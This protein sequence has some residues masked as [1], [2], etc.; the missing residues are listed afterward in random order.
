MP[1][2]WCSVNFIAG[3][4]SLLFTL[5]WVARIFCKTG[6]SFPDKNTEFVSSFRNSVIQKSK[7]VA[8]SCVQFWL[9]LKIQQYL[10]KKRR[11]CRRP[12]NFVSL[13]VLVVPSIPLLY[14]DGSEN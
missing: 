10:E 6:N 9:R 8:R 1:E 11:V 3:L 2:L 5:D 4:C 12:D 14:P 13:C 7:T